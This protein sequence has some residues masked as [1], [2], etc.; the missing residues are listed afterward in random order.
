[1]RIPGDLSALLVCCW[2]VEDHAD[3]LNG[4]CRFTPALEE[5]QIPYMV[6]YHF[7]TDN[8]PASSIGTLQLAIAESVQCCPSAGCR[9]THSL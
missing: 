1:V 7:D 5:K 9:P 3:A 6:H 4:A 8:A 2:P